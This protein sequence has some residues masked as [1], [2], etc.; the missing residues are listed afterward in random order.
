MVNRYGCKDHSYCEQVLEQVPEL[1][2]ECEL[3]QCPGQVQS[4]MDEE[5]G[6]VEGM[7]PAQAQHASW[8]QE[9]QRAVLICAQCMEDQVQQVPEQ[10]QK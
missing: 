5:L 4:D 6:V 2:P 10:A 3:E 8:D 7:V 1:I 9:R